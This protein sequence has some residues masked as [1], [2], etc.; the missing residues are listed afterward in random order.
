M[1]SPSDIPQANRVK[2]SPIKQ[3]RVIRTEERPNDAVLEITTGNGAQHFLL[4]K[5]ALGELAQSLASFAKDET[6]D[7][8]PTH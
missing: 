4:P 2:V 7:T 5:S 1:S 8:R 3:V 6:I